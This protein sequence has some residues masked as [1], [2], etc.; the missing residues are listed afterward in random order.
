MW[1]GYYYRFGLNDLFRRYCGMYLPKTEWKSF[2]KKQE[3]NALT[4][5]QLT[6]SAHDVVALW[7]VYQK[8][9]E[10][11]SERD[12]QIWERIER[13]FLWTLCDQHGITLDVEKW[14]EIADGKEATSTELYEQIQKEHG[15]NVRSPKQLLALL[16]SLKVKVTSTNRTALE[17]VK[18][19]HPIVDTILKYRKPAK[20]ASTYGRSWSDEWVEADGKVWCSYKQIGTVTA[21]LASANPNLQ[22][23]P[24]REDPR[25]RDCFIAMPGHSLIIA[26]YA[27]QEPRITAYFSQDEAL[28]EIFNCGGDIYCDVG[29]HVFGEKFDKK[30]PRRKDMKALVLGLSYGMTKIGLAVKIE[31]DENYAQHLIDTFFEKFPGVRRYINDQIASVKKRGY[32]TTIYGRKI[33]IS[34]HASGLERDAPNYSIQA[35]AADATKMAATGFRKEWRKRYG[36]NPIRLYVHDEIVAEVP[37]EQAEEASNVLENCM[38]SVAGSMTVGVPALADVHIGPTWASKG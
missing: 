9:K 34:P 17:A 35:S 23:I 37:T 1:S 28:M 31:K 16:Q 18:G 19:K 30:D 13:P 20:G 4:D 2:G 12:Q 24:T 11:I 5:A 8:Q 25:Y 27:S 15:V 21:R 26:D 22:N 10:I 6:Y 14:N 38:V 33:W 3:Q 32:V 36:V 7:M 29:E